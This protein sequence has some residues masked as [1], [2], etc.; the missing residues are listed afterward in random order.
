MVNLGDLVAKIQGGGTSPPGDDTL[1]LLINGKSYE[2]WQEI[3]VKRSMKAI[4]GSFTL[5]VIDKW[6]E[7]K[8]AWKIAPGD[9]CQVKIGSDTVI[10]GY[11]DAVTPKFDQGNRSMSI[12]GRDKTGDLVDCSVEHSSGTWTNISLL[13][14]AKKVATP[15]GIGVKL[16]ATGV[17]AVFPAWKIQQGESAFETLERAARLRGV[18]LMND[19][20]GNILITSTSTTRAGTELVQGQNIREAEGDYNQKERF[21]KYIVKS[22][23]GGLEGA[24]PEVDFTCKGTATD[25]GVTR[26][27]PI[28]IVAE[29]A[30]TATVCRQRA[31]WESSVRI[32]KSSRVTIKVVGW[33]KNDGKLW[34]VNELTQVKAPW[35]GINMELL[36]TEVA[37]QKGSE[38]TTQISL[39]PAEA[40]TPDPTFISRKDP[41]RQLVIQESRRK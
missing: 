36:I 2:G 4:S 11:V 15:F 7:E 40:Y 10:T 30:S 1:K 31:K 28:M 29:G 38:T 18:L 34:A 35:I 22:Q 17:N 14:L 37:F 26:Y 20:L 23:S 13:A 16:I 19:G 3:S 6:A 9:S 12:T 39:E 8:V 41:W 24:D 5:K 21:S 33:R 25:P 27:R 32:G